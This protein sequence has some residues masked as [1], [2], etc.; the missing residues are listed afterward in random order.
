MIVVKFLGLDKEAKQ[1]EIGRVSWDGKHLRLSGNT[2][3]L[4][5]LLRTPN[6]TLDAVPAR[7]SKNPARYL[8]I[9]NAM[10]RGPMVSAILV[11]DDPQIPNEFLS[12][13]D[14]DSWK[15]IELLDR[16]NGRPVCPSILKEDLLNGP[17]R[18]FIK[19]AG[20]VDTAVALSTSTG[21]SDPSEEQVYR[22]AVSM[23][24]KL[25][26]QA[27]RELAAI[28][29]GQGRATLSEQLRAIRALLNRYMPLVAQ[30][31][32]D[33]HLLPCCQACRA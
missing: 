21:F 18:P 20:E 5:R 2:K 23:Y 16:K 27:R 25:S 6:G 32:A 19:K 31:I 3:A 8:R 17:V 33:S 7:I 11:E 29:R 28:L 4:K 22:R 30:S 9:A 15:K 14:Y 10:Y 1:Y 26:R 13:F 12:R 24:A